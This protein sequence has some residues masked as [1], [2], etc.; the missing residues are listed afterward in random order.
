V[1]SV[2]LYG[3][4]FHAMRFHGKSLVESYEVSYLTRA[5]SLLESR[6]RLKAGTI[7]S[8]S[9]WKGLGTPRV[10]YA[11]LVELPAVRDELRGPNKTSFECILGTWPNHLYPTNC[12]NC[13]R[14]CYPLSRPDRREADRESRIEPR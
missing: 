8:L 11:D 3:L 9:H 6:G 12:G 7:S 2:G 13:L 4:P 5:G 1:P 14:H 10:D